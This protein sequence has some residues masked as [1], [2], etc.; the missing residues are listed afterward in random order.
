MPKLPE[1]PQ[2]SP[3]VAAIYQSYEDADTPRQSRR[4]GASIIGRQ[5]DR[6]LWYS[7]RHC[8]DPENRFDGRMLRLFETGHLEEHRI[9]ANLRAIGCEVHEVDPE[10]GEQFTFTA[11]NGHV[12]CKIDGAVRGLPE[13]PK[14]WH[15]AE[16][17]TTN[18]KG[19]MQLKK[20]GLKKSKPEHWAQCVIG[21][22]LSDM[23]RAVYIS[24]DKD[25]DHLYS[26]RL[27]IEECRD[28]GQMILDRAGSIIDAVQPPEKIS[29]DRDN[30]ACRFC[31]F[32]DICHG[33]EGGLRA[34]PVSVSCRQCC[35]ATPARDWEQGQWHCGHHDRI[36]TQEDQDKA[37]E[38]HL[39]IP[40]LIN[41]AETTDAGHDWIAYESNGVTWQ[42]PEYSS[43]E[44]TRAPLDVIGRG[45]VDAVK[46]TL[47]GEIVSTS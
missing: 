5:C 15:V 4:L 17:K 30:F 28:E 3:T 36:I 7:F 25:T 34:V 45:S 19:F 26:E 21:M 37:C 13:A 40:I 20:H 14:A 35:H 24:R 47:G 1:P 18:H 42:Q 11:E 44:L 41:G 10:T 6:Q 2:D 27:R 32:K 23:P 22:M 33:S 31:D 39:F 8:A 12:V 9:V 46:K 29:D 43:Q 38:A 16:F